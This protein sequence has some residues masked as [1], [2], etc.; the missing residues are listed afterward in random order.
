ME[1]GL[2]RHN[3]EWVIGWLDDLL[4]TNDEARRIQQAA[5]PLTAR[6]LEGL[7]PWTVRTLAPAMAYQLH[8]DTLEVARVFLASVQRS[9]RELLDGSLSH[10]LRMVQD[11]TTEAEN[12]GTVSEAD[13]LDVR[14]ERLEAKVEE[15]LE[16]LR[17][18]LLRCPRASEDDRVV[19]PPD[20]RAG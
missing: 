10:R 13:D 12:R 17:A 5:P 15:A 4:A 16:L 8:P 3:I 1:D 14:V 20:L 18:H 19:H 9:L 7:P 11:Q 6:L 2:D